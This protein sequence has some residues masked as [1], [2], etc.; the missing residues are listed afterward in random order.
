[1]FMIENELTEGKLIDCYGL[2]IHQVY[3]G[4][5]VKLPHQKISFIKS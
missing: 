5:V 1:M 4:L 2:H 3:S